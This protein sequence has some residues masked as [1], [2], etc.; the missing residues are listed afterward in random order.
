[1]V[2]VDSGVVVVFEVLLNDDCVMFEGYGV[3]VM[4]VVIGC[5]VMNGPDVIE[6]LRVVFADVL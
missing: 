5:V 4:F 6:A 1:V 3:V 2:F